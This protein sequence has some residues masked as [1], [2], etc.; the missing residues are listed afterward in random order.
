MVRAYQP[1]RVL[2]CKGLAGV[3]FKGTGAIMNKIIAVQ[4]KAS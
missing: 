1:L 4:D 3:S 2:I